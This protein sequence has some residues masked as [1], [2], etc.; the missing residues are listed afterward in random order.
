MGTCA[1]N[2][3]MAIACA[4]ITTSRVGASEVPRVRI[5]GTSNV[6]V[7]GGKPWSPSRVKIVREEDEMERVMREAMKA[8]VVEASV[9][10][11]S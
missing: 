1:Q 5:V 11:K 9:E 2:P 3:M 7:V 4:S 8:S 10:W 6:V